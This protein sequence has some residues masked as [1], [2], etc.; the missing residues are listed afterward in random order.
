MALG[1]GPLQGWI[2]TPGERECRER[3]ERGTLLMWVHYHATGQVAKERA[4]LKARGEVIA[5]AILDRQDELNPL[6]Q[7]TPEAMAFLDGP[8]VNPIPAPAWRGPHRHAPT[9]GATSP[10]GPVDRAGAPEPEGGVSYRAVS[11][12]DATGPQAPTASK[13]EVEEPADR[14]LAEAWDD[15]MEGTPATYEAV[16]PGR[17]PEEESSAQSEREAA[18]SSV[19]AK[20]LEHCAGILSPDPS[21]WEKLQGSALTRPPLGQKEGAEAFCCSCLATIEEPAHRLRFAGTQEDSWG[22]ADCVRDEIARRKPRKPTGPPPGLS[23]LD[24]KRW[25]L[26][27]GAHVVGDAK[28]KGYRGDKRLGCVLCLRP[29][30]PGDLWRKKSA[31][32]NKGMHEACRLAV[33]ADPSQPLQPEEASK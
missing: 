1:S 12:V 18:A 3:T 33:L 20:R 8:P 9:V 5:Q 16:A 2:L 14:P 21:W 19:H 24:A 4:L 25:H 31:T 6:K 7:P 13:G 28:P 11:M 29:I 26:A 17:T 27:K 32:S 22:H 15:L 30:N 10:A 23:P